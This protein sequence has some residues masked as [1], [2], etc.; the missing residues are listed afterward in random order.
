[1]VNLYITGPHTLSGSLV[2]L[3]HDIVTIPIPI[4]VMLG[5]GG[6]PVNT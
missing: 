2:V 3:V 1:M 4:T 5:V 6:L